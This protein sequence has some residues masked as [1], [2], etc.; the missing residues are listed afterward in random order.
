MTTKEPLRALETDASINFYVK[1]SRRK[2]MTNFIFPLHQRPD[3]SYHEGG[4]KYG[5]RRSNGTRKHAGCDLIAPKGTQVLAMDDGK[6]IRGPY[7]FYSGTYAL[8]IKHSNGKVV[9]YGEIMKK[10]LPGIRVGVRVAR[11]Q[12]IARVGRLRSGS[13]MLHLE[14][15][16]GTE[17]GQLTQAGNKYKRRSDLINPTS[18]LDAASLLAAADRPAPD[19]TANRDVRAGRVNDKLTGK[20]NV[21]SEPSTEA[22]VVFKMVQGDNCT[23]LGDSWYEIERHGVRG[24]AASRYIDAGPEQESLT[25]EEDAIITEGRVNDEVSTVLNV[26]SEPSRSA[27]KLFTFPPGGTVRV[28]EEVTGDVYQWDR[29]DWLKIERNG[30]IGFVAGY[31]VNIGQSK[32]SKVSAGDKPSADRWES[33]LLEVPTSGASART[34]SQD[35]LKKGIRA[36]RQMA[37]NDLDSVWKIAGRF[38]SAAGKFGIPAAILAA[39][40]SRE[41]RCGAVL[42][43][44]WGDN[45]NAFGIMQIDKRY[46][47]ILG[48]NDPASIEHI[49]QAAGIFTDY[50]EQVMKKHP[51][52][53][54]KHAL[55][56]AAVAYNSGVSNVN[57][58]GGMDEGTTGED[59]GSDVIARAQHYF[60]HKD[61]AIFRS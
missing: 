22:A 24:Y 11:G 12:V 60:K 59:Y 54:D 9:R 35:G 8:E 29:D 16:K 41:A 61:L 32:S 28:L 42:R 58:I 39:L 6:V 45:D 10:V 5:S 19:K 52:W 36:S 33:A 49:E 21:R 34:A 38:V 46:H 40:A 57:T 50:L 30:K 53:K 1:N 2:S 25:P 17:S 37:E 26:R 15:Y 13:S 55:K 47:D 31:F 14:I 51:K 3:P 23:V 18:I 43:R 7:H 56:G 27:R 48:Q 20:L 4:R 44:G